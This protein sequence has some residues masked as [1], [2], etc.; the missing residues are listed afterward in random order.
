VEHNEMK[1]AR[2]WSWMLLVAMTMVCTAMTP[3]WAAIIIDDSTPVT[4]DR[5]ANDSSYVASGY[6]LSGVARADD[7]KWVTLVSEN[8]FMSANHWHPG[9]G[10]TV[11]FFTGNDP[12]G[13]SITRT[14]QG[15]Q[16][17]SGT[18]LWLGVLDTPVPSAVTSYRYATEDFQTE[19]EAAASAY[20]LQNAFLFGISGTNYGDTPTTDMATGRNILDAWAQDATVGGTTDVAWVAVY[21]D[22]SDSNY[23]TYEACI[24]GGD[25]GGPMFVDT[26]DSS[27][28]LVG[29]NWG[30]A[31]D[32]SFSVFSYTGNHSNE[33]QEYIVGNAVPEPTAVMLL[34][35]GMFLV[36]CSRRR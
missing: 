20:A 1:I 16:G 36:W 17:I 5:F 15:G 26:G 33:I 35:L 3:A 18:D 4:N 7:G 34:G 13:S 30:K 2:R 11:R 21:N 10:E 22:P 14:V 29:F 24:Q 23:V 27:L 8:V 12:D 25:S 9:N 31:S 28:S 6:D 32:N 19:A